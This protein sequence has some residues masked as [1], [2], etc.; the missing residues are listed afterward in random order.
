MGAGKSRTKSNQIIV[1]YENGDET[2]LIELDDD[3]LDELTANYEEG[4]LTDFTQEEFEQ[5]LQDIDIRATYGW[6]LDD[7]NDVRFDFDENDV[8]TVK[9]LNED[10]RYFMLTAL[11]TAD[12]IQRTFQESTGYKDKVVDYVMFGSSKDDYDLGENTR[13]YRS[14]VTLLSDDLVPLPHNPERMVHRQYNSSYIVLDASPECRLSKSMMADWKRTGTLENATMSQRYALITERASASNGWLCA[15]G[16]YSKTT[17][18][19]EMGHAVMVSMGNVFGKRFPTS[20]IK[21]WHERTYNS[22]VSGYAQRNY[23]ES[24]AECFSLYVIGG[25]SSSRM[26]TEFSDMMSDLGLSNMYGC[27]K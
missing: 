8:L 24:F 4:I 16:S 23:K 17:M 18:T 12:T 19:H 20:A 21:E 2:L 10:L 14:G 6:S 15:S 25:K 13:G 11:D 3:T 26:Y 9:V 7:N 1:E 22:P 27:V 5:F